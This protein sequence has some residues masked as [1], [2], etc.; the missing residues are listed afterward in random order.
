MC[1][2]FS[3][4]KTALACIFFQLLICPF[5]CLF[6]VFHIQG[7]LLDLHGFILSVQS[8]LSVGDWTIACLSEGTLTSHFNRFGTVWLERPEMTPYV[9]TKCTNHWYLGPVLRAF[10]PVSQKLAKLLETRTKVWLSLLMPFHILQCLV[11]FGQFFVSA[12]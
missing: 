2:P 6:Y 1:A 5:W 11:Q 10:Y 12:V 4:Y 8:S 9:E 7:L 3:N